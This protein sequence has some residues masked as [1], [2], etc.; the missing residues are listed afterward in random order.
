MGGELITS[1]IQVLCSQIT[2]LPD[3]QGL[4]VILRTRMYLRVN[5][6]YIYSVY[7][8]IHPYK[9]LYKHDSCCRQRVNSSRSRG[10]LAD[11]VT[12]LQEPLVRKTAFEQHAQQ[13]KKIKTMCVR[14]PCLE[15]ASAPC[16]ARKCS[17]AHKRSAAVRC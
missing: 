11:L 17:A 15:L 3:S 9:Q 14:G 16:D 8:I 6:S 13:E 7:I 5:T 1:Q 10:T 2:T 4:T 12:M